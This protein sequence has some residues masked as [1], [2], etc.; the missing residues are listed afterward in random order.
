MDGDPT[1]TTGRE[2]AVARLK[3]KLLANAKLYA[4]V[5]APPVS[6]Q[7]SRREDRKATKRAETMMRLDAI[8]RRHR[9]K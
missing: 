3:Q 9:G 6:R 8:K 4:G 5:Y 7:V 2:R 1:P